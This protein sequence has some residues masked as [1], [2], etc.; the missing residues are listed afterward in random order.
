MKE[1][2]L[3][4]DSIIFDGFGQAC[5]KYPGKFEIS[6]WHLKD[7]VSNE[8][9]DLTALAGS[10]IALTTYYKSNVLP[11]VTLFL[12]SHGIITKSILHLIHCL[13]DITSLLFFQVTVVP[14]KLACFFFLL[15]SSYELCPF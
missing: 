11:P 4:V 2:L 15:L 5:P 12:S 14:C 3:Q 10:N 6:L 1:S 8:V 13:S 7:E 9:R